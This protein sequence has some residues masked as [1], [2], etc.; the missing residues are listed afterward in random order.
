[1]DIAFLPNEHMLIARRNG[2]IQ[3]VN[4][5]NGIMNGFELYLD[6]RSKTDIAY[7]RGVHSIALDPDFSLGPQHQWVYIYYLANSNGVRNQRVSRWLHKDPF[8][9]TSARVLLADEQLI[10]NST[11][12]LSTGE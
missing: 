8:F 5:S 3:I 4:F 11:L 6:L 1:M 2:E 9:N 12:I 10:F 7:E